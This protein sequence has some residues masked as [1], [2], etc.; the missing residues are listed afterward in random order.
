MQWPL[1]V[2]V[3]TVWL[4]G[5]DVPELKKFTNFL[6]GHV[7]III[8]RSPHAIYIITKLKILKLVIKFKI[9][10]CTNINS[11]KSKY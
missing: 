11:V 9:T 7:L 6:R 3:A 8:F 2:W 5:R 4:Y 10:Y 1:L